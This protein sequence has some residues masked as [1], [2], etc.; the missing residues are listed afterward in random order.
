MAET[1]LQPSFLT[2]GGYFNAQFSVLMQLELLF[3]FL[4]AGACGACIGIERTRRLK[5]AGMRTHVIVCC[6]AALMMVVSKYGFV[7]LTSMAGEAFHGVRG[8]DSARIAAQVVSGVSFLGAGVMFKSGN[9]IKG[10]T[11]AAGVWA[12]AGVG[13]AIG[14]GMYVMGVGF[15]AIL[16]LLQLMMHRFPLTRDMVSHQLSFTIDPEDGFR[17]K[18][19][20]FLESRAAQVMDSEITYTQN[21]LITYRLMLK[22]P[23]GVIQEVDDYLHTHGKL[24]TVSYSN[25]A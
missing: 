4:V 5:E 18:F 16:I 21:G 7:D 25:I 10:L 2:F 23:H 20:A 6:S 1:Y 15:T 13:L 22:M 11:T 12:T 14:A 19:E 3:R 17:D 24:Q 8:A 9:T